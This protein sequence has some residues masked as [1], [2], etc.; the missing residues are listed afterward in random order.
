M[1]NKKQVFNPY[2]PSY[3][4]VPD[5]EPHVFGGRI[6]LYGS[7]DRCGSAGFC[8]NDYVCYS[9]DVQNLSDWRYEGVIFRKDQDPRN[10]NIPVNAPEQPLMFDIRPEK[11]G[12]LNPKGV[13]A[14]WAPDVVRGR[15]GRYYLYYCLD[16]LPEIGVAVCDTPAGKYEFMG[17]VRHAD[18]KILGKANGDLMQFDPGVFIDGDE[19]YL[20]SGNAPMCLEHADST[21]ASQVMRLEGDM[22]TLKEEPKRL[23]PDIRC[24]KGTGFEGHEFFEASSIRRIGNIYYFVYSSVNSSELCYAVSKYPD[25]DYRYGGTLVDIGDIGI[26]GRTREEALNALGNTHGGI[27]Q[28]NGQW[29]V[30]YHRQ[31]NRT[32][33]SRQGCAE[34]IEIRPDG[35]IRQ[36]EVTSCGMNTEPLT[37]AGIYP[38]RICCRLTGKNGAVESHP[39]RMGMEYSYLTQDLPDIDPES[40]EAA[41]EKSFPIQY[42]KNIQEGT[43][44]GYKYFLF[45][46]ADQMILKVRGKG[47]GIFTIMQ[48]PEAEIAGTVAVDID[49]EKWTDIAGGMNFRKGIYPLYLKYEGDGTIDFVTFTLYSCERR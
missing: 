4:Y 15:D 7:H 35:T 19:I 49:S 34:K 26:N 30:F 13:H 39:K 18:G 22:I 8:L 36:A 9:A 14:M 10:Q 40:P 41:L 47:N 2:L 33:F 27:E 32:N 1:K 38:A 43:V 46:N 37:D 45:E 29:Y 23:L 16:F 42:I 48:K 5:G 6:Y 12:D 31:T 28:I 25:R 24:S 17:L 11:A 3:E 21:H 20:Y 44:I